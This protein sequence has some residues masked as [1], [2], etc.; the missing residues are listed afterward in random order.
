MKDK[1]TFPTPKKRRRGKFGP[2]APPPAFS[3][4][5]YVRLA[6]CD[7]AMF[8][9]LLEAEDNLAYISTA[10]RWSCVLRVVFSPHQKEAALRC[11]ESMRESIS[12]EIILEGAA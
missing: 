3:S 11:L 6:P 8:R 12:F 1:K 10:D 7:V 2:P 4:C 9:F 5:L